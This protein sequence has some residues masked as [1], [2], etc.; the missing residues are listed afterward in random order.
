[1]AAFAGKRPARAAARPELHARLRVQLGAAHAIGPGKAD[2][3]EAIEARGSLADAAREL[4][5][6]YMRAWHLV[7]EMNEAFRAP[8]VELRRGAQGGATLTSDGR[9]VLALYR[10]MEKTARRAMEAAW[11]KL[12]RRLRPSA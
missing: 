1:M 11:R 9:A 4:G 8:L 3:L 12:R 6:S 10:D 2:L 5:M 7:R